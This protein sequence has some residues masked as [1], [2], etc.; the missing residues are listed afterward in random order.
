MDPQQIEKWTQKNGFHELPNNVNNSNKEMYITAGELD[1]LRGVQTFGFTVREQTPPGSIDPEKAKA[2]GIQPS[3]KYSLLKLGVPVQND[4]GTA[5]VHPED[6]L[7]ES[8][9]ARK[10]TFLADHRRVPPEMMKLSANS[11]VLIHEATLSIK[12][13]AERTREKIK[14][15]G[16]NTAYNAGVAGRML[17]SKVVVLNHFASH[18]SDVPSVEEVVEEA[19]SG[20]KGACEIVASYDF[21]ELWIPRGGFQF[22]KDKEIE[23]YG[24]ELDGTN[25]ERKGESA[26]AS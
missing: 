6:V 9:R 20:N 7:I 4:D 14:I 2:L 3:K 23:D 21:M 5:L 10:F 24:H 11:D 18:V 26:I 13:G 1:H 25:G 8:F 15:R 12:D 19:K 22:E 17:N 16:H